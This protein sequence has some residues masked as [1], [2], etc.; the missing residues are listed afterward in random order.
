MA[1]GVSSWTL[2]N[3]K[4]VAAT[5][6][7]GEAIAACSWYSAAFEFEIFKSSE[8]EGWSSSSRK[9]EIVLLL[10]PFLNVYLIILLCYE[11]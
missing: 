2:P 3:E 10:L 8:G 5:N 4:G 6:V 1:S 7:E 9:S 11:T